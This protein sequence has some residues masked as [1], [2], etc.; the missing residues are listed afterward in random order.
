MDFGKQ[1]LLP[2][3]LDGIPNHILLEIASPINL[4]GDKHFLVEPV[5]FSQ[6]TTIA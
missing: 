2:L 4:A 3:F 5:G 1:N 6:C